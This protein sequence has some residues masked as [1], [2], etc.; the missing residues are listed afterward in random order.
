MPPRRCYWILDDDPIA[1]DLVVVV[2]VLEE[3]VHE[4]CSIAVTRDNI[5]EEDAHEKKEDIHY[6]YCHSWGCHCPFSH[7]IYPVVA[8]AAADLLPAVAEADHP[9]PAVVVDSAPREEEVLA[10]PG[11]V[12]WGVA[13]YC[14]F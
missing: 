12:D 11:S 7:G 4:S 2:R 1:N 10:A 8:A 13:C 14:L 5:L 6:Y 3:V 9:T